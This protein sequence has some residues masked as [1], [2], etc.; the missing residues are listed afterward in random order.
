MYTEADFKVFWLGEDGHVWKLA[1]FC[2]HPT[3]TF[4]RVDVPTIQRG[5]AVGSPI[6]AGFRRLIPDPGAGGDQ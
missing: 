4:A 1:H 6:L 5:G 3:A 2:E